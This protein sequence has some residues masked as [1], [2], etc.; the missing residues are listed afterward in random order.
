MGPK[1]SHLIEKTMTSS[2]LKKSGILTWIVSKC[3][4]H[5]KREKL[6]E[7]LKKYLKVDVYGRCGNQTIPAISGS[8]LL[9]FDQGNLN[10]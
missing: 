7:N 4:T 6:V 3:T 2:I 1:L 9:K 8:S 5:S 10:Q